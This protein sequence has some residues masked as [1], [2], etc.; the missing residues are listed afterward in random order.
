M[1]CGQDEELIMAVR[2]KG[3]EQEGSTEGVVDSLGLKLLLLVAVLEGG[4]C[5]HILDRRPCV[6]L[7]EAMRKECGSRCQRGGVAAKQELPHSREHT[8]TCSM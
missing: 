8:S 7:I 5:E 2:H 6:L 1:E 4:L 3:E